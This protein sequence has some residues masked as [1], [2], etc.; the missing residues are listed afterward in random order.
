MEVLD[1]VGGVDHLAGLVGILEID[2]QPLPVVVPE[3]PT[4]WR[5]RLT[6]S[7][8][9]YAR[10]TLQ[11]TPPPFPPTHSLPD[12]TTIQTRHNSRITFGDSDA[13]GDAEIL[14]ENHY[15]PFGMAMTISSTTSAAPPNDYLYNGK[16]LQTELGLDWSRCIGM[17]PG[18][19]M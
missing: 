4:D 3:D 13:D 7:S 5:F 2:C 12:R 15:Y 14:Q 18:C 17:E 6:W 8:S 9:T 19:M 16:E 11:Q 10:L 1:Q